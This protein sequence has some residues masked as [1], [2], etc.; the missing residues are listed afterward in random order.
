MIVEIFLFLSAV[1][2]AAILLSTLID[3]AEQIVIGIAGA[4]LGVLYATRRAAGALLE[5]FTQTRSGKWYTQPREVSESELPEE[6]R[7]LSRN[8]RSRVAEFRPN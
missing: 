3:W 2:G 8:D 5:V 6:L 4:I 1:A 7:S